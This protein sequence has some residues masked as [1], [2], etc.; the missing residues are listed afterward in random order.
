M[1]VMKM[2]INPRLLAL[3]LVGPFLF[4]CNDDDD[5]PA[6]R[7][8]ERSY[9]LAPVDNSGVS[10]KVTFRE[11]DAGTLVILELTGTMAGETH[12][13]HIHGNKAADGGPILIDLTSV[14]G[15]TGR[16]ETVVT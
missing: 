16:S 13:A 14:D 12:P 4:A 10:G 6:P 7:Q 9:T 5:D 2:H 3:L 8:T 15:A 1:T 11:Q